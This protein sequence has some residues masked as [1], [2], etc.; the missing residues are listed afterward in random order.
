M[1]ELP[2]LPKAIS[3]KDLWQ[4]ASIFDGDGDGNIDSWE[5]SEFI[6]QLQVHVGVCQWKGVVCIH[7]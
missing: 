5:Y 2:S 6:K 7:K 1:K 4:F 3:L